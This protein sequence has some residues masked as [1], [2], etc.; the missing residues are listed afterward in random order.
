M[1][2]V[3]ESPTI[4]DPAGVRQA[5]EQ[6]LQNSHRVLHQRTSPCGR[7]SRREARNPVFAAKEICLLVSASVAYTESFHTQLTFTSAWC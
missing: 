3:I 5:E 4:D 7:H 1:M 2:I 6:S